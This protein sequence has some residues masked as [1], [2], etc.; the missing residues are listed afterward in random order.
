MKYFDGT[1]KQGFIPLIS[2]RVIQTLSGGLLGIF[3]PI[4]LFNLFD[5]NIKSVIYF[6]LIA[7]LVYVIALA[8]GAQFLNEFGFRR[9]LATSVINVH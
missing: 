5:G 9:A 1:L 4:F 2:M 8:W 3:L 7:S 6:F